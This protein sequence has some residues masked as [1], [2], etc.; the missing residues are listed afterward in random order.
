MRLGNLVTDV[1]LLTFQGVGER[2]ML[3]RLL[4]QGVEKALLEVNRA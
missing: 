3:P 4:Q 2:Q 1:M